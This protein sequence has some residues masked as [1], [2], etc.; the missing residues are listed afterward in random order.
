MRVPAAAVAAY[1]CVMPRL[2]GCPHQARLA[3][4]AA[5]VLSAGPHSGLLNFGYWGLY[6]QAGHSYTVSLYMRNPDVRTAGFV[7]Y[8]LVAPLL[9]SCP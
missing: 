2:A 5:H 6:V 8:C 1:T 7:L 9:L 4:V 3:P